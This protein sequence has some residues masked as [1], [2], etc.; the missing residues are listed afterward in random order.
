MTT[1][2]WDC[3]GLKLVLR[4]SSQKKGKKTNSVPRV[5]SKAKL[6]Q[7][8]LGNSRFPC[9]YSNRS[10]G[11]DKWPFLS[12]GKRGKAWESARKVRRGQRCRVNHGHTPSDP[13]R[14]SLLEKKST[15]CRGNL[16]YVGINEILNLSGR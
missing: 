3:S 9:D 2:I 6:N 10:R 14:L 13:L 4:S 16:K 12:A 7:Y 1:L 15:H 11:F 5:L 8:I